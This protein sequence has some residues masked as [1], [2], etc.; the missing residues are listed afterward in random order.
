M[1]MTGGGNDLVFGRGSPGFYTAQDAPEADMYGVFDIHVS[2]PTSAYG[3]VVGLCRYPVLGASAGLLYVSG[4]R[5]GFQ[6]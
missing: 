5:S 1:A 2:G 3:E 4:V 6:K